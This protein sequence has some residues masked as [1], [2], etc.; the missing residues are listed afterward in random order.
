M[1]RLVE[2]PGGFA[3]SR[4]RQVPPLYQIAAPHS[5]C[6]DDHNLFLKGVGLATLH[7]SWSLAATCWG[8]HHQLVASHMNQDA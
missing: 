6:S 5:L 8:A 2:V 7:E 1:A 4:K 3:R